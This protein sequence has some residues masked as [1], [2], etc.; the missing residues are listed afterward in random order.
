MK[1]ISCTLQIIFLGDQTKEIKR[2]GY[3]GCMREREQ[4]Y[5]QKNSYGRD[6]LGATDV[7]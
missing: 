5:I 7:H 2:V 6:Y 1:F 4:K 3:A